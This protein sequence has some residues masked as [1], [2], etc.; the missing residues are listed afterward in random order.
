M[1]PTTVPSPAA[2]SEPKASRS[3]FWLA[4][5]IG[6]VLLAAV[7]CG[8]VAMLVGLDDITLADLQSSGPVWTP[9]PLPTPQPADVSAPAAGSSDAANPPSGRLQP[10]GL[11]RNVASSRVNIRRVP[12]Y[13]GKGDED[14]VAQ[15]ESGATVTILEWP[16]T[17][18]QLTWWR[19][20]YDS[21]VGPVEGWVA[22]STA[23]GV[24]ILAPE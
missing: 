3:H 13:L 2:V 9:P 14:I 12:G 4:F 19:I 18:D 21:P 6:F 8:S 5:A 16:Q 23:S 15:M 10:N 24:L 20:R 7:S 22:E 1:S 11:A 17:A